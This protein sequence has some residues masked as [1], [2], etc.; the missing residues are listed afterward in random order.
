[1]GVPLPVEASYLL[2]AKLLRDGYSYVFMLIV[3]T[4][5]H[6]T[7][8]I[9]S[10]G[11]GWWGEGWLTKRLQKRPGFMKASQTIHKWYTDHG[12]ITIFATR[13]I[14]YVRPWSSMVAGFARIDFGSFVCWT[15]LGSLLFNIVVLIFTQYLL[16]WWYQFGTVFKIVSGVLLVVSFSAIFVI[17]HFIQKRHQEELDQ[18]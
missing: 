18:E 15:L 17:H 2:A 16:N 13:F 12:K 1:M 11:L 14:G 3:L 7:G 4:A 10:F 5:A 9:L 8:S 6:L